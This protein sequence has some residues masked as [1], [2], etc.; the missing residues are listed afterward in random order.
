MVWVEFY[1]LGDLNGAVRANAMYMYLI[2]T[3]AKVGMWLNINMV[4]IML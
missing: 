1:I 2:G 4:I 3:M